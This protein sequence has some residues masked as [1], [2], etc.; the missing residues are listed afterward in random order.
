MSFRND[1]PRDSD[2]DRDQEYAPPA[3]GASDY[4]GRPRSIY[5]PS[6]RSEYRGRENNAPYGY[7]APVYQA[8]VS[9]LAR[10]SITLPGTAVIT[11]ASP[12]RRDQLA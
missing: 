11:T 10:P 6:M 2:R 5:T 4:Y 9:P 8:P 7:G 12:S 1:R 3:G